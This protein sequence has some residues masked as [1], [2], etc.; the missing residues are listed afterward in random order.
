MICRCSMLS[1]LRYGI[2]G[3]QLA[4]AVKI[5]GNSVIVIYAGLKYYLTKSEAAPGR[6]ICTLSDAWRGL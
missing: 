4:N 1:A 6:S 2:Y 3:L 5:F